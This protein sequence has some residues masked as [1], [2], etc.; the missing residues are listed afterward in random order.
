MAL[1]HRLVPLIARVSGTSP[2]C[3][4]GSVL[5]TLHP[6][7]W[8]V[9]RPPMDVQIVESTGSRHRMQFD[10]KHDFWFPAS[11]V[12]SEEL[13]S[14]YLVT[15][16][17]H[18]CNSHAYLKHGV[19]LG[20]GDTVLDCG[21]CE[22]FFVRQALDLGVDKV[23]C[24]E[25]NTEMVECLRAS[26]PAEVACGR[27]IILPEAL[28]AFAGEANFSV[29]PGD[30]FSGRFD[31]SGGDRVP[32]VT[33]DHL[34]NTHGIPT[35]IKMDLEGSEYDALKGGL[36][37]FAGNRPKLAITTYHFPWDYA[38]TSSFLQG[39]GY[40][41]TRVSLPT[42]RDTNIPRPVMLHAWE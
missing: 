25:P 39:I 41:N 28:G 5:Q 37:F 20:P 17:E 35:M 34:A 3:P 42:M 38:V 7:T 12:P 30:A 23:I 13:W 19:S 27:L 32:L 24:V 29:S 9:K 2:L 31:E 8:R 1:K 18:R 6:G 33:L 14:E 26:F 22:G 11:M 36:E 15:S 4:W 40:R 21:A 16:W 10:G